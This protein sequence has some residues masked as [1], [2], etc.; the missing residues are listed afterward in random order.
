ML[1]WVE[2]TGRRIR[3]T[4]RAARRLVESGAGRITEPDSKIV[5]ETWLKAQKPASTD[6]APERPEMKA[7]KR[8][9]RTNNAST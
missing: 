7:T 2:L 9:R 6:T 4:P 1:V 5:Y 3:Q 8:T